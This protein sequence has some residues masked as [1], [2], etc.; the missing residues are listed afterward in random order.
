MFSKLSSGVVRQDNLKKK[1]N[2]LALQKTIAIALPR[3][4]WLAIYVITFM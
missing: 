1:S 2:K 3:C 4:L